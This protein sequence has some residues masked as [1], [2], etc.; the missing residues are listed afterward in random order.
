MKGQQE[1]CQREI[2]EFLVTLLLY[3]VIP[4]YNSERR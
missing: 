1:G 2:D 3:L 4:L